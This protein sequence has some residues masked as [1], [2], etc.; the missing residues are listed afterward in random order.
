MKETR[1]T[2][3]ICDGISCYNK[4]TGN[5]VFDRY[6]DDDGLDMCITK[7]YNKRL[8]HFLRLVY[9]TEPPD[10]SEWMAVRK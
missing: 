1:T 2:I 7:R 10:S 8:L 4:N 9:N 6:Y 5:I 3:D